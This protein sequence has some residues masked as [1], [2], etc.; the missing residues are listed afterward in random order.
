MGGLESQL[1]LEMEAKRKI[2]L[3][4]TNYLEIT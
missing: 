4:M 1:K 3:L 2:L